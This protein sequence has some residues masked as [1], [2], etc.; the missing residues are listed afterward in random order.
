MTEAGRVVHKFGGTS[1]ADAAC[2]RRVARII[3]GW[4]ESRQ[5]IVVSARGGPTDALTHA[6]ELAASRDDTYRDALNALCVRHR[7]TITE[8]LPSE[9]AGPV[10]AAIDR[11]IGDILDVLRAATLLRGFSRDTMELVT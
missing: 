4:P 8:L 10:I 9:A 3:A 2:F 6:V 1:L 7:D 5:A 11:D